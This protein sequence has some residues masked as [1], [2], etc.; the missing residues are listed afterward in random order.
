MEEGG[1]PYVQQAKGNL[2]PS[3]PGQRPTSADIS[4]LT[5]RHHCLPNPRDEINRL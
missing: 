2:C 1:I 4:P 5:L 3:K